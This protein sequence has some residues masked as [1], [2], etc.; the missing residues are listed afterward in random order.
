MIWFFLSVAWGLGAEEVQVLSRLEGGLRGSADTLVVSVE[1]PAGY[2]V[3]L[4]EPSA[5]G[6]SFSRAKEPFVE[7]VG[8]SVIERHEYR[9]SGPAGSYEVNPVTARWSSAGEDGAVESYSLFIDH[10]VASEPPGEFIDIIEPEITAGPSWATWA[11]GGGFLGLFIA[12]TLWAFWAK[13]KEQLV[14]EEQGPAPHEV[15]L[16]RWRAVLADDSMSVED[17]AIE[18]S[19]L[20]RDY[21]EAQL[22]FSATAWTT[23]ET[24]RHLMGLA[25]LEAAQLQSA[26]RILR[27]TDWVKYAEASTPEESLRALDVD[28][29]GFIEATRPHQWGGDS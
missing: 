2:A 17:K 7:Q 1:Y 12:G 22:H 10:Q 24:M 23:T 25:Y 15:A 19:A 29:T 8:N 3:E 13:P 28:L 14:H 18:L 16:A 6:L 5:E 4:S 26:K 9:F 27:A 21:L 20:F 11:T